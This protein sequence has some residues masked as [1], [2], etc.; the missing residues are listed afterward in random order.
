MFS[1]NTQKT[2][3]KRKKN[4]TM[5][6]PV[7]FRFLSLWCCV[8]Q[9]AV[10][11]C[12][13]LRCTRVCV[14]PCGLCVCVCCGPRPFSFRSIGAS[15]RP[16]AFG[17]TAMLSS[18]LLHSCVLL[19]GFALFCMCCCTYSPSLLF[20]FPSYLCAFRQNHKMRVKEK[21]K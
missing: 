18:L 19:L 5:F 8:Y 4:R 3:K 21:K 17:D 12:V 2:T 15:I 14:R 7:L 13:V 16:T 9:W 20:R 1:K 11:V 10:H 6:L